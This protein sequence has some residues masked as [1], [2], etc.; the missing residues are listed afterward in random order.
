MPDLPTDID[1]TDRT[2]FYFW[3]AVGMV[4]APAVYSGFPGFII[5]I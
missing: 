4:I 1:L 3:T 5:I 2:N